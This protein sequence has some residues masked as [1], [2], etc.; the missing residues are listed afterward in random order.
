[1]TAVAKVAADDDAVTFAVEVAGR[2]EEIEALRPLWISLQGADL[3]ADIDYFLVAARLE[4]P[5]VR[6]HVILLRRG[7]DAVGVA[8]AKFAACALSVAPGGLLGEAAG[9]G[10]PTVVEQLRADVARGADRLLIRGLRTQPGALPVAPAPAWLS[11]QRPQARWG[12]VLDRSVAA[13]L[14]QCSPKTRQNFWRVRRRLVQELGDRVAMRVLRAPHE[15]E[16][17]FRDVD[18]VAVRTYQELGRPLYAPDPLLRAQATLGLARG[19]FRAYMLYVDGAPIAF[20]TGFRYGRTFGWVG[21]TGYDPRFRSL[22]PGAA[23]LGYVLEDLCADPGVEIFDLG[24]GD[25]DF[26]RRLGTPLWYEADAV[27]FP[28]T[29][30]G[31]RQRARH[32]VAAAGDASIEALHVRPGLESCRRLLRRRLGWAAAT[33]RRAAG[34]DDVDTPAR[35]S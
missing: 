27:F 12:I 15:R 13:S 10:L 22:S 2:V 14:R 4:P 8:A 5:A 6:P 26:K 30:S 23:L 1:V 3:A 7:G 9:A 32:A 21:H 24:T 18:R 35:S 16:E 34:R 20:W 11:G 29:L 28:P 25:R 19:W 31:Y 33:A 17:I